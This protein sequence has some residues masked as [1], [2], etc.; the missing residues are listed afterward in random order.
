MSIIRELF[1]YPNRPGMISEFRVPVVELCLFLILV[2][3]QPVSADPVNTSLIRNYQ[4]PALQFDSLQEQVVVHGSLSP[5]IEDEDAR[6]SFG[7]TFSES[8]ASTVIPVGSILYYSKDGITTVFDQTGKQ[9]LSADDS[10]AE[11]IPTPEGF[12]PATRVHTVPSGSYSYVSGNTTYTIHNDTLLYVAIHEEID[13][14]ENPEG[15]TPARESSAFSGE[16]PDARRAE[17]DISNTT[18]MASAIV[19]NPAFYIG[20]T[21]TTEWVVPE[22]P[23]QRGTYSPTYLSVGISNTN[24]HYNYPTWIN[25]KMIIEYDYDQN[26]WFI[27][28]CMFS[29]YGSGNW[30]M[31]CAGKLPIYPGDKIVGR[32]EYD[33]TTDTPPFHEIYLFISDYNTGVCSGSGSAYYSDTDAITQMNLILQGDLEYLDEST[34]IGNVTFSPVNL[35]ASPATYAATSNPQLPH[36]SVEN[37]WPDSIV[38]RTREIPTEY[39]FSMT[40]SISKYDQPSHFEDSEAEISN[41]SLW[42]N[43][44]TSWKLAFSDSD[45]NATKEDFGTQG[46]GLNNAVLHWHTGHGGFDDQNLEK[47]GLAIINTVK[48][49]EC[50]VNQPKDCNIVIKGHSL[51]ESK[52]TNC[53][54]SDYT[55]ILTPQEIAGKWNKNNKWV[56]LSS[57]Q[58]LQDDRWNNALGTTHGI[59]GFSTDSIA[60]P[61]LSYRFFKYAMEDR[62]PL[63]KA[64]RNATIDVYNGRNSSVPLIPPPDG[65]SYYPVE[66]PIKATVRFANETQYNNDHLPGYGTVEPD[67]NPDDVVVKSW[68]CVKN[69]GE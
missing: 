23:R 3:G 21:F 59:F 2:A 49:E 54:I 40:N 39:T 15:N 7:R 69:N 67:E 52:R 33:E 20:D 12:I 56:V 62:L 4:L 37:N 43:E 17:T 61:S 27:T 47:S 63:A 66:V 13:P 38:F 31:S 22:S 64:W 53:A 11:M 45:I 58:V 34:I 25:Q 55:D 48:L 24:V 6:S 35:P 65:Y 14:G 18:I 41:V 1:R 5:G 9:I 30:Q 46:G 29:R 51:C 32:I 57:C 44:N 42:L 28:A 8:P 60:D 10:Q 36:L 68:D 16:R 19:D 50:K 26:A